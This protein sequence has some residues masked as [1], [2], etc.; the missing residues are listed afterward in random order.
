MMVQ[1][2][3]LKLAQKQRSQEFRLGKK[4]QKPGKTRPSGERKKSL[5]LMNPATFCNKEKGG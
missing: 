5:G 1:V 2:K 3:N 4:E